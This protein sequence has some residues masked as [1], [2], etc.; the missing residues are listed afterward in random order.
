[1]AGSR[2]KR[3][4][5]TGLAA[6][7]PTMLTFY[8]LYYAAITIHQH[9]GI[10]VNKL[11]DVPEDSWRVFVGDA[12]AFLLLIAV[13]WLIGFFLATYV[14]KVLFRRLDQAFR[15][16]PLVRVVYPAVK[17]VSD[18]FLTKQSIPFSR[19]VAAEYPRRGIY[20]VGFLT[21]DGLKGVQGEDGQRLVSVFIPNTPAPLTGFT[22]LLPRRDIVPLSI[23]VD[24][25]IKFIVSGGVVVPEGEML[26]ALSDPSAG[27]GSEQAGTP[28][29]HQPG[30]ET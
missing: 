10:R 14:G 26:H 7:V 13:V 25:A 11:F 3:L 21:G 29:P 23:T 1:M 12:V 6:L 24:Q 2:T 9:V 18:F 17:Q 5:M 8:L 20:S 4:L 16:V 30:K 15:H 28:M 27:L 19:V 22:I